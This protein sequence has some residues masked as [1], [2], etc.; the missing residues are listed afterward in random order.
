MVYYRLKL[1]LLAL[2]VIW[3]FGSAFRELR[4]GR[5]FR[6]MESDARGES[7]PGPRERVQ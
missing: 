7:A 5:A 2:G 4:A 1:V 3:G 6:C